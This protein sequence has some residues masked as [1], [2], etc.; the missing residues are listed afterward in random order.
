MTDREEYHAEMQKLRAVKATPHRMTLSDAYRDLLDNFRQLIAR[1]VR[2]RD[3]IEAGRTARG[4]P[5]VNVKY[6]RGE[7]ETR[8]E[9]ERAT[10]ATLDRLVA[11]YPTS[12]GYVFAKD[13][14][15]EK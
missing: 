3:S 5:V 2:E 1:P 11:K 4:E 7:D 6:Y 13:N 15:G 12:S 8:E 9:L 10:S 14:G